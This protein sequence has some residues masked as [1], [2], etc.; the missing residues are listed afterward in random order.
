ML[1]EVHRSG[2]RL[3]RQLQLTLRPGA[4]GGGGGPAAGAPLTGDARRCGTEA[5]T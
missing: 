2:L 5:G 1:L 4:H 3:L